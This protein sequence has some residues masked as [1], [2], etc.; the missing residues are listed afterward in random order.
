MKFGQLFPLEIE[1]ATLQ[2]SVLSSL[3]ASFGNV[4]NMINSGLVPR[5][6]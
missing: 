4:I 2:F 3:W 6:K 1:L 5:I